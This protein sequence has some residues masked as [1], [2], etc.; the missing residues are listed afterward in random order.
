MKTLTTALDAAPRE[1]RA[2]AP[3][4][5]L[6]LAGAVAL[7]LCGCSSGT[8]MNSDANRPA[9]TA[10]T[11]SSAPSTSAPDVTPTLAPVPHNPEVTV[12][13]VIRITVDG[14]TVNAV[15]H[16]NAAS[17]S[18][19]SQLPLELSFTDYGGQEKIASIPAPLNLD[20]LPSGGSAEP[21]TVGY[22][23]PDQA[24]VL[25]YDSVGYYEGIIPLGTFDDVAA[26]RHA[27]AFTGII[28]AH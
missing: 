16:N 22:Y 6:V 10:P 21:G 7:G 2:P 17:A 27:P 26:V 5:G 18:L 20:G 28:T 12:S 14:A 9:S 11:A 1:T 4:W 13:T 8:P 24:I 15:L 19:V 3:G 23:A 25:Y